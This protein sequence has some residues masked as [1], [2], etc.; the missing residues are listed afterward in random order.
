MRR[1]SSLFAPLLSLFI[2][3]PLPTTVAQTHSSSSLVEVVY[4]LD[5]NEIVTYDVDPDTGIPT[6]QGTLAV[7]PLFPTIIPSIDDHFLYVT[8]T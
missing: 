8:G 6:R 7:P 2:L 1:S 5:H 3:S 4:L